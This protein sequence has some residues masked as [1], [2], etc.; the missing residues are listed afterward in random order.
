MPR[1]ENLRLADTRLAVQP[2]WRDWAQ[3]RAGEA[4]G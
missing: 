1:P 2:L 4:L 3:T